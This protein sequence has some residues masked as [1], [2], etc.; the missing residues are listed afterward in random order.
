[1]ELTETLKHFISSHQ[2]DDVMELLLH[3]AKYP[4]VDI[5]FAVQQISGR[6]K[7]SVKFPSL[8]ENDNI[9]YPPQLS[10]EQASSETT[11]HYKANLVKDKTV[12]DLTGGLGIDSLYMSEAAKQLVYVEHN[13][14]LVAIARHNFDAMHAPIETYCDDGI[15]FLQKSNRQ[16]DVLYIDPSRRNEHQQRVIALDKYE[17]NVLEAMSLFYQHASRFIIKISPMMDISQAITTLPYVEKVHIIAIKNECK[18]LLFECVNYPTETEITAVHFGM[19]EDGRFAFFQKEEKNATAH[20]TAI[21][22]QY[23]YEPNVALMKAGAYRLLAFRFSLEKLHPASHLYTSDQLISNF[24]GR[25]FEVVTTF[26]LNKASLRKWL[27]SLQANVAVRNFPMTVADIRHKFQ[28]KE[29]GDHYLFASTFADES[30]GMIF[31]KKL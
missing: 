25:I 9:I 10:M 23:L 26:P 17:P 15:T 20:Y 8:L 29:G 19:Q 2:H 13:P 28:L 30:K 4:D 31:C 21:V 22:K 5:P 27:P 14:E 3:A 12:I 16:F 1:M 11:A 18:E 6:R 24:P 7:A